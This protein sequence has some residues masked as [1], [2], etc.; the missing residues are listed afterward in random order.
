MSGHCRT[1]ATNSTLANELT[2]L[3][4]LERLA[5]GDLQI[6]S[7]ELGFDEFSDLSV[8]VTPSEESFSFGSFGFICLSFVFFCCC[9]FQVSLDLHCSLVV[10][11]DC[12][13]S[14]SQLDSSPKYLWIDGN[15]EANISAELRG[16]QCFGRTQVAELAMLT[17]GTLSGSLVE[18]VAA[19]RSL[20]FSKALAVKGKRFVQSNT[21]PFDYPR[22]ANYAWRRR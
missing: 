18:Y 9:V 7:N 22:M 8:K 12:F 11:C 20:E 3:T 2:K 17:R 13:C 4:H 6:A 15:N 5:L 19:A 1:Y 16:R 10:R 14:I 21:L